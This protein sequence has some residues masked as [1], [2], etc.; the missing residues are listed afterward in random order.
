MRGRCIADQ[1]VDCTGLHVADSM[2]YITVAH[3]LAAFDVSKAV[4]PETGIAG[5][6][7]KPFRREDLGRV[8]RRAISPDQ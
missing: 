7:I 8:L 4:D 3:L 5:C 1:G 6:L 2:V